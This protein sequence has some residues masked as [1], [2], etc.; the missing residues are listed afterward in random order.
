MG[1]GHALL[2][3]VLLLTVPGCR[4][5]YTG[6]NTNSQNNGNDWVGGTNICEL[7]MR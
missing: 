4:E 7:Y 1:Y 2:L 5:K 6:A 3:A